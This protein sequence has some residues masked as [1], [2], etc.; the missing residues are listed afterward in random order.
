MKKISIEENAARV[1]T[2]EELYFLDGRDKEGPKKGTFTGLGQEIA[3]YKKFA[4]EL[5]IYEKWN[6]RNYPLY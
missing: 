1:K 6:Q 5:A 2:M 4:E 3:T